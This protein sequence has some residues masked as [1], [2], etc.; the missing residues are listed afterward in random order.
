MAFELLKCV[1]RGKKETEEKEKKVKDNRFVSSVTGFWDSLAASYQLTIVMN[2]FFFQC[3]SLRNWTNNKSVRVNLTSW[4]KSNPR[5]LGREEYGRKKKRIFHQTMSNRLIATSITSI[6]NSS[7]TVMY[8][9]A[10]ICRTANG[11]VEASG[12]QEKHN[13]TESHERVYL[14]SF[15]LFVWTRKQSS[16]IQLHGQF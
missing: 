14:F 15:W 5:Q 12:Q 16:W 10:A 1:F 11:G 2:V 7:P 4:T 13:T 8:R 9:L 3:A 6:C